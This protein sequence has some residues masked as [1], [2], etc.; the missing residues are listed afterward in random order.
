MSKRL[1]KESKDE[2]T[3]CHL[4]R[5]GADRRGRPIPRKI[6]RAGWHAAGADWCWQH[7]GT[8]LPL[9]KVTFRFEHRRQKKSANIDVIAVYEFMSTDWSPWR[10]FGTWRRRWPKLT[11]TLKPFYDQAIVSEHIEQKAA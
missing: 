2:N 4:R 5:L 8:R 10:S 7:W 3:A 1:I 6:L 9:R 11:F